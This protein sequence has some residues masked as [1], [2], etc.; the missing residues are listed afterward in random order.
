[1]A[2]QGKHLRRKGRL[3]RIHPWLASRP[4]TLTAPRLAGWL[5]LLLACVS[6]AGAAPVVAA[7][8][9]DAVEV[10][11]ERA[12]VSTRSGRQPAPERRPHQPGRGP[13]RDAAAAP[14]TARTGC[15]RPLPVATPLFIL[16]RALLL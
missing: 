14:A 13:M 1:M 16:Q 15:E 4:M 12:Y 9:V 11:W 3:T 5:R 8:L 7:P 10:R 6:F 2:G